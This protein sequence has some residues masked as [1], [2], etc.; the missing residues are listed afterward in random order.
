MRSSGGRYD[1]DT[2]FRTCSAFLKVLASAFGQDRRGLSDARR[3][4]GLELCASASAQS[5]RRPWS[6]VG[7]RSRKPRASLPE[8]CPNRA[9]GFHHGSAA[10]GS[11]MAARVMFRHRSP[12][13]TTAS[14]FDG[15]QDAEM[16][17]LFVITRTSRVMT[18]ELASGT[19]STQAN[20]RW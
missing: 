14:S 5:Y 6:G 1:R 8:G 7:M 18:Q 16:F 20:A 11:S 19:N 13:F 9:A 15:A 10:R 3:L 12:D 2:R 17:S 4:H